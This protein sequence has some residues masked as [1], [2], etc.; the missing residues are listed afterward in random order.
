MAA[1]LCRCSFPPRLK[2]KLLRRQKKFLGAQKGLQ[3]SGE[4][5]EGIESAGSVLLSVLS[6]GD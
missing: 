6:V 3:G 4:T 1:I 2:Q 5:S